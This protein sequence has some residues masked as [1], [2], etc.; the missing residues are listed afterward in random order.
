L[1]W[2]VVN[3]ACSSAEAPITFTAAAPLGISGVK[4][5]AQLSAN[6]L[7]RRA[8]PWGAGAMAPALT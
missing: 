2:N 7:Y 6:G 5:N 3:S 4:S 8:P 1:Q